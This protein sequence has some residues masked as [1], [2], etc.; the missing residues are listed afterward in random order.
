MSVDIG[1][2]LRRRRERGEGAEGE[3]LS[4]IQR[5]IG[6]RKGSDFHTIRNDLGLL[7]SVS[8]GKF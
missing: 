4:W 6:L 5:V 1:H 3:P 2:Q 8:Y 7:F